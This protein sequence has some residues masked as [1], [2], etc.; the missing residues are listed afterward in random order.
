[1]PDDGAL[2]ENCRKHS[3]RGLHW[4]NPESCSQSFHESFQRCFQSLESLYLFDAVQAGGK[5]VSFT[6]CKR[7][8]VGKPGST[9]RYL[10]LRLFSHPWMEEDGRDDTFHGYNDECS[11]ALRQMGELNGQLRER[12][13]SILDKECKPHVPDGLVGSADFS[14]TLVNRMAPVRTD[15]KHNQQKEPFGKASVSWHKDSGL[16]DFS[17]IAVYHTLLPEEAQSDPDSLSA[18]PPSWRVALR[19]KDAKTTPPLLLPLPS[20]STYYLLDDFNHQHEHA[21]LAGSGQLRYSSTHR[22]AREGQ[23]TWQ[24]LKNKCGMVLEKEHA[25]NEKEYIQQVRGRLQLQTEIEFEWLRQWYIQGQR[26]A[27]LHPYWHKPI[28]FLEKTVQDLQGLYATTVKKLN[29]RDTGVSEDLF[30]VIIEGLES[31]RQLATQW[32]EREQ[33]PLYA[34]MDPAMQPMPLPPLCAS[35]DD[36]RD[37]VTKLRKRRKKFLQETTGQNEKTGNLTKK[38]KRKIASN[39]EAMKAKVSKKTKK[40]PTETAGKKKKKRKS[41]A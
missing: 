17:S 2:F 30:D 9:Y 5:R 39:W 11:N 6:H 3:Y 14:L 10:G 32:H 18:P 4:E 34:S 40:Q 33:D 22:V 25:G 23:G 31:R 35:P 37:N 8:L 28:K 21:V 41:Q 16:M 12:T 1:M 13:T 15:R 7:T 19:I 27:E 24:Y 38:E 26:H 36:L 29:S 20:G